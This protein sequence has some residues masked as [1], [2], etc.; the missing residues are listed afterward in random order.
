MN[1]RDYLRV[2]KAYLLQYYK[3]ELFSLV[4]FG[5]MIDAIKSRSPST[6]VDLIIVVKD[7]CP[8]KTFKKL[9]GELRTIQQQ[10]KPQSKKFWSLF[11]TGLQQSTGMFVNS[12]LCYYSDFQTRNFSK[13]F[14]VNSA[15][16]FI[17]APQTSVWISLNQRHKIILGKDPF[18]EWI[19]TIQIKKIDIIRSFLMNSLLAVGSLM[20]GIVL[21]NL[22]QYSM[23][24]VKWSLFVWWNWKRYPLSSIQQICTEFNKQGSTIENMTLELF[25]Q[26]RKDE[27]PA[28]YLRI[29]APLFVASLHKKLLK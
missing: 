9:K 11:L 19:K 23:E 25:L 13:V 4:L 12:F 16:S 29:L 24:S 18:A 15:I 1:E 27:K 2:V 21:P 28:S 3:E 14:E 10:F 7:N 5:S 6:D 8:P 26:Y 20:L 17:L 22:T